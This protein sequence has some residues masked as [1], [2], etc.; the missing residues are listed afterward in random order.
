MC[1][2]NLLC[3]AAYHPYSHTYTGS[4]LTLFSQSKYSHGYYVQHSRCSKQ[5]QR[6]LFRLKL[7][8]RPIKMCTTAQIVSTED[9]ICLLIFFT[10]RVNNEQVASKKLKFNWKTKNLCDTTSCCCTSSS[11]RFEGFCYFH[12]EGHAVET[13]GTT[14]PMKQGRSLLQHRCEHPT[15]GEI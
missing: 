15:P 10:S 7:I 13:S 5:I 8:C 12:P 3:E 4:I 1:C 9:K 11:R 14:H 6:H 2:N